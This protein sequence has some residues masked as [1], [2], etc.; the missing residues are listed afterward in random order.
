MKSGASGTPPSWPLPLSPPPAAQPDMG[1]VTEIN[2]PPTKKVALPPNET[3]MGVCILKQIN[4]SE[5]EKGDVNG[6]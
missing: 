4:I 3:E 6:I 2:L 5:P 1:R